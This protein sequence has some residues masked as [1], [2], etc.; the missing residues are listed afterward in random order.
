MRIFCLLEQKTVAF[1]GK[2]CYNIPELDL[3]WIYGVIESK[4]DTAR[5]GCVWVTLFYCVKPDRG[6][7]T[8]G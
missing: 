6:I 5:R 2:I 4:S 7:E 1:F 8:G 3:S